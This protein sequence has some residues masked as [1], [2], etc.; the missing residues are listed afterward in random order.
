M[1]K[2]LTILVI[3]IISGIGY[4][5][6]H[7]NTEE[8]KARKE[9][10]QLGIHGADQNRYINASNSS[11]KE[12]PKTE[13][14]TYTANVCTVCGKKFS[15]KGYEEVADGVW[16]QCKEPYQCYICSAF[17]GRIQTKKMNEL[18]AKTSNKSDGRV[19]D[20]DACTLCKGSGLE[21][22]KNLATGETEDR[23]CPMCNGKGVKSY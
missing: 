8:Y 23:I 19:Y 6:Y 12:E 10:D 3:I 4:Y 17:C 11:I 16:E 7:I 14:Q 21:S 18:V 13:K 22:G 5:F 9:L 15:G 20:D 1:K 2:T